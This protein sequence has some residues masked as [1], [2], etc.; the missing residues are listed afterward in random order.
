MSEHFLFMLINILSYLLRW[1]EI[2][3]QS[4]NFQL[5][6]ASEGDISVGL[7][8]PFHINVK[9]SRALAILAALN[10]GFP[11]AFISFNDKG[12]SVYRLSWR[13]TN[14]AS[15]LLHQMDD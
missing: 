9:K 10:L 13:S 11:Q 6:C 12:L 4:A 5:E 8:M 2:L 3:C 14:A 15:D 1:L 7:L